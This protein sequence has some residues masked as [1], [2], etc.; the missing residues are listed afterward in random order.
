VAGLTQGRLDG[1]P[2]QL[3]SGVAPVD[4]A[5]P[6]ELAFL[7]SKRYVKRVARSRAGAYLVASDLAASLPTRA[8]RVVV[9]APHDAL[10]LLLLHFHPPRVEPACIHPTAVLGRGA[11]VGPGVRVEPY[12]V[13]GERVTIGEGTRVGAHC[14]LGAGTS[15][16]ARCTLHPHVVC[17]DGS[18]IG[19]DVTLH[20]GVRLGS[21]GFGYTTVEGE[22]LKMPQVGR[23][24][25]EAG[26]EIGANTTIDRGSL[27]D[28]VVGRGVKI[29]NLVQVAH[30]VRVGAAT[31]IAALVGIAGSTRIGRGAWFGG[32]ASATN[33]LEIGDEARVTFGSTVTRDVPAHETVSGYPARPHREHLRASA[34]AARLPKLAE[35][36]GRLESAV[37]A[38][39]A[40]QEP[41]G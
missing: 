33:H 11:R 22:H 20:S 25:V 31:M 26:A 39:R 6:G 41:Y 14:V 17:Y 28:T 27:G 10:R 21:D 16:G 3:V 36:V 23:A 29:D 9:E 15:V 19:D 32:R 30:N 18:V 5:G 38:L 1:S 24:V 8:P 37:A 13:L 40:G 34:H 12:A 4:E 2:T 7:A 35:R